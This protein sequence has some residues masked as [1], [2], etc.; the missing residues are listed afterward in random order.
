[1]SFRHNILHRRELTISA[2]QQQQQQQK[3]PG[4]A[5]TQK[6]TLEHICVVLRN[7]SNVFQCEHFYN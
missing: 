6:K 3:Q 5:D 2:K 7:K 4:L 1:V